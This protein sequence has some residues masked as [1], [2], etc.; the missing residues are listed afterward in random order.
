MV[1]HTESKDIYITKCWSSKWRL[2]LCMC[3]LV[4]L[5]ICTFVY[6]C[7]CIFVYLFWAHE[8]ST[9]GHDHQALWLCNVQYA[10]W[11]LIVTGEGAAQALHLGLLRAA[12][13]WK[14]ISLNWQMYLSKYKIVFVQVQLHRLSLASANELVFS[15]WCLFRTR[16]STESFKDKITCG[17]PQ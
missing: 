3:V 17:L 2:A 6:F 9:S 1:P 12:C 13:V 11:P 14:C 5:G 16:Q 8:L 15:C 4:Y 7:I 10:S